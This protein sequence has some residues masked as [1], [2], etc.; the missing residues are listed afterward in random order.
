MVKSNRQKE[1][2]IREYHIAKI[3]DEKIYQEIWTS[4]DD[5]LRN[6]EPPDFSFTKTD[7]IEAETILYTG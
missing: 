3:L 6:I 7:N 1:K 2:F 5:K 4:F